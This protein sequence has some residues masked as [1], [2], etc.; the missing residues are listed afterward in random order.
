MK[1]NAQR[2]YNDS[3]DEYRTCYTLTWSYAELLGGVF[4]AL[5]LTLVLRKCFARRKEVTL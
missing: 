3:R 4:L 5:L 1:L 2:Y